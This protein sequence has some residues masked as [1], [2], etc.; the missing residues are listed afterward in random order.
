MEKHFGKLNRIL[1]GLM[2]SLYIS[3][4]CVEQFEKAAIFDNLT[5]YEVEQEIEV[6]FG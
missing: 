5:I 4:E 2:I 6:L 3:M 1:N